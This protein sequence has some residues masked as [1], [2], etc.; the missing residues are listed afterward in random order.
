MEDAFGNNR[1]VLLNG[2]IALRCMMRT[3]MIVRNLGVWSRPHFKTVSECEV[4]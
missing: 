4:E 3:D 2:R 1:P